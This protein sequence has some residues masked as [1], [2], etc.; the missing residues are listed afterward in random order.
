MSTKNPNILALIPARGG[1]KGIPRK[2]VR[3]IAGRPLIAYAIGHALQSGLIGRVIVSTDDEEIAAAARA[4][5]AEVPF[6]RPAEFAQDLSPDLDVFRH[7]LQWLR[8][9]EA[10]TPE[11]V[12]HLRPTG[13]VRRIELIDEA[14]GR[15]LATPQ[16]DALRAVSVPA[17][18]PYKMWRMENG[19]LKPLLSIPGIKEPHSMAR[20]MLPQVYW[21]NGYVDIV[22]PRTVLEMNSMTGDTVL[23]F[24]VTDRIFELDY[25]ESI[26]EVEQVLA[27]LA[28]GE[29][30]FFAQDHRHAV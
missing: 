13:P 8:D 17:L 9:K 6:I 16:A 29:K 26:P 24:I 19:F 15:M 23:P 28:R 25:E 3:L 14:I 12:V 21:Q 20:Q 27:A 2:N 4:A 11:L 18:T 7:A 22:R 10:Y 5:G 30:V 1:S